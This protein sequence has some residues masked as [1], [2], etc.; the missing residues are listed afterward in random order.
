MEQ[1]DYAMAGEYYEDGMVSGRTEGAANRHRA[2]GA[3]MT[4]VTR[5]L[6]SVGCWA[7]GVRCGIFLLYAVQM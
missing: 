6:W 7:R 2:S 5:G 3:R 1:Y 4:W